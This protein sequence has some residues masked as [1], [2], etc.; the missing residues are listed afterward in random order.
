MRGLLVRTHLTGGL[1]RPWLQIN[2]GASSV[3][4]ISIATIADMTL[5]MH[6][7]KLTAARGGAG[8]ANQYSAPQR[9]V[10]APRS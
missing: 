5:W 3:R 4:L 2:K 8:H 10:I 7:P 6:S 1:G 9:D